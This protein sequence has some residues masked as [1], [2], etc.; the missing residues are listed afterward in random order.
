MPDSNQRANDAPIRIENLHKSF[1]REPVLDGINLSVAK[2]ET[3]SV[4]GRSGTGK[5]VLLK[6]IIRLQPADA[7]SI[8]IGGQDIGGLDSNELNEVRKKIGFLFQHA[9]LYDSLTVEENVRFPLGRHTK[10]PAEEQTR[11]VHELLANVGMDRETTKMPSEVS[12]GMQK[13]VG[14]ARPL[15]LDPEIVLFDEPTAGLDPITAL[16]ISKLIVELKEKRRMT[17][18]IVTHDIHSAKI[19]ADRLVFLDGGK[20]RADGSFSDLQKSGDQF[21]K[22][23]L[24]DSDDS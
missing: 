20:I 24:R 22:K 21:V 5:S 6:L 3:V 17:A 18:I 14:W 2:G 4:L 12:G 10:S 1:G 19:F 15:A 7:G 23:F 8:Q 9:A 11:R 13:R 16:E